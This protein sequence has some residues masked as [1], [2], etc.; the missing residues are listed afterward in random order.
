MQNVNKIIS[1]EFKNNEYSKKDKI[2]IY[3]IQT[4]FK[5]VLREHDHNKS[6]QKYEEFITKNE[7]FIE[8]HK[9]SPKFLKKIAKHLK[10]AFEKFY[11][12]IK[13]NID[14]TENKY[15][16]FNNLPQI[17]HVKNNSKKPRILLCRIGVVVK[18]YTQNY[19]TREKRQ[20]FD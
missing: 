5:E 6:L 2:W 7:N 8:K 20:K 17:R 15:E 3:S 14:R 1:D 18:N 11:T 16:I 4:Q 12:Y 19:R 9:K 10:N 13:I